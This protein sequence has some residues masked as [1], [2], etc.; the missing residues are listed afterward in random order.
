MKSITIHN[1]D[2]EVAS[3]IEQHA[4]ETGLSLNKTIKQLLRK[5]L[6]ISSD[7]KSKTSF[8]EFVGVWNQDD[9]E[10]FESATSDLGRVD[11]SDWE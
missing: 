5:A 6:N 7:N 9:L 4:K 2:D 3:R 8:Q 11:D 1:L 10:S